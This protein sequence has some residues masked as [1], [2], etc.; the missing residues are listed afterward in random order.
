M[1]TIYIGPYVRCENPLV[2]TEVEVEGCP[3]HGKPSIYAAFCP[4]C[5]CTMRLF[6]KKARYPK[7]DSNDAYNQLNDRLYPAH[8]SLPDMGFDIFLPNVSYGVRKGHVQTGELVAE[9]IST[10]DVERERVTFK[11]FFRVEIEKLSEIYAAYATQTVSV[12]WGVVGVH[13]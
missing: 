13:L 2:D 1:A 7:V 5:G 6:K 4:E 8:G 12:L 10:D 9:P 11:A 3:M